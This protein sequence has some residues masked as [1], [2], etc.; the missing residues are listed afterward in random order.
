MARPESEFGSDSEYESETESESESSHGSVFGSDGSYKV[1][2]RR[3]DWVQAIGTKINTSKR[4]RIR[5][6][7]TVAT[8]AFQ[9]TGPGIGTWNMIKAD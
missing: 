1:P 4:Y 8:S 9:A 6:D 2:S 3:L 7:R 5:V